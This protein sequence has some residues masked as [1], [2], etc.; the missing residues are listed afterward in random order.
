MAGYPRTGGKR[1]Y[2]CAPANGG[3]GQSVLAAPAEAIV[4][5]KVLAAL[6]DAQ[7]LEAMRAAD[8]W[9]DAQREKLAGVLADLDA[10]MAETEAKRAAAPRSMTRLRGQYDRNLASM[11]ARYEA[12]ERELAGLGSASA[13]AEP[14]PVMTAE[15]WDAPTTTAA[16][17]AAV[18][19]RLDGRVTILPGTR[20]RGAS[21]L[22]FDAGRV[23][24]TFGD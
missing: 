22:P 17:K 1:A 19:R 15:D 3:C 14:L 6:A 9:L 13:P 18:I 11:A 7:A 24:V 4:R 16:R 23:V 10:D 20:P 2:V 12:A 8:V 5:D 21:R